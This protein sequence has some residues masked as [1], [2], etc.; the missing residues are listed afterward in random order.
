MCADIGRFRRAGRE[1]T[2]P[3]DIGMKPLCAPDPRPHIRCVEAKQRTRGSSSRSC[4]E[5]QDITDKQSV[6][7]PR[8]LSRPDNRSPGGGRKRRKRKNGRRKCLRLPGSQPEIAAFRS[9]NRVR[10]HRA[11][12][13]SRRSACKQIVEKESRLD[14]GSQGMDAGHRSGLQSDDR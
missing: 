2:L 10:E 12:R 13:I 11:A 9:G 3:T 1:C 8:I 6:Y 5:C 7:A 14:G 4:S